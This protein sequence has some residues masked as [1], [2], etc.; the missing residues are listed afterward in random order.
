MHSKRGTRT[1]T[2]TVPPQRT[3]SFPIST[4][5]CNRL[6]QFLNLDKNKAYLEPEK[7]LR[8]IKNTFLILSA[9][10]MENFFLFANVQ[11]II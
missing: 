7:I 3:P 8:Q 5:Y 2:H 9:I 1:N 4:V 6:G 11:K 10:F